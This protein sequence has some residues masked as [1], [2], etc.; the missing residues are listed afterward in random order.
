MKKKTI[1]A[2]FIILSFI[3]TMQL[4]TKS[5]ADENLYQKVQKMQ[6]QL[7]ETEYKIALKKA[8]NYI[9]NVYILYIATENKTKN[10]VPDKLVDYFVKE[11]QPSMKISNTKFVYTPK[12][13]ENY[14]YEIFG[15][16]P[17]KSGCY[18]IIDTNGSLPPNKL[19]QT[20]SNPTDRIRLEITQNKIIAPSY[21]NY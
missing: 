16:A 3:L 12:A 1:I 21:I 6:Q 10:I 2:A 11:M 9:N 19:W 20:S 18:I 14:T 4:K 13:N 7:Q 8:Y 5:L 17:C 15:T